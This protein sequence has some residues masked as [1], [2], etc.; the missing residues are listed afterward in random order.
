MKRILLTLFLLCASSTLSYAATINVHAGDNLQ[1][2]INNAQPGDTLILDAG[3][4]FTGPITLPA[5][6]G[7]SYITI[8]SSALAQLPAAGVRVS[9]SNSAQMPR[10]V[11]PGLGYAALMTASGASYYSFIGVEFATVNPNDTVDTLITLGDGNTSAQSILAQIPHHLTF[12][13]CY[14]HAS[15]T[16]DLKRGIGLNSRETSVLNSYL[17][18]FKSVGNDSQ[19]IGGWNGPG[20]FHIINNYLEGAGENILFGGA[21]ANNSNNQPSDIEIRR[22]LITKPLSWRV[23]DPSYAGTHWQVKNL[24]EL[25]NAQRVTIEGNILEN[26]W[27]D[28]QGGTA[29][30]F[31][32]RNQ[33]GTNLW[34]GINNVTFRNNVIRHANNGIGTL[35]HDDEHTSQFLHDITVT[36]NLLYDLD[37][38]VW[39]SPGNGGGIFISFN[40][41]G[42]YNLTIQH[43]TAYANGIGYFFEANT[44]LSG[45]VIKDNISHAHYLWNGSAGTNALNGAAPNGGWTA[46]RDV[47]VLE[48]YDGSVSYWQ[49]Y[50]T[51]P[52]NTYLTATWA[53]VGFSNASNSN[54]NDFRLTASSPYKGLATDGKDI[55]CDI[56]ALNAA[57]SAQTQAGFSDDFSSNTRDTTKWNLGVTTIDATGIDPSVSVS[58]QNGQLAITPKPYTAGLHYNGYTTTQA[59]DFTGGTISVQLIQPAGDYRAPAV[60]SVGIDANNYCRIDVTH[61]GTTDNRVHMYYRINGGAETVTEV[62]NLSSAPAY[63]RLR[64]LTTDDTIVWETSN[65]G[66]NWTLRRQAAGG[67]SLSSVHVDL[68]SGTAQYIDVSTAAIFDNFQLQGQSSEKRFV[69]DT[70]TGADGTELSTHLGETGAAWVNGT[71]EPYAGSMYISNANRLRCY[72]RSYYYAGGSPASAEYDIQAD[73]VLVGGTPGYAGLLGRFDPVP[74]Y[75]YRVMWD[76]GSQTLILQKSTATTGGA[77]MLGTYTPGAPVVGSTHTIKLEIRNST[78]K[79]Y[80]DGVPVI[81]STDNELTGAGKVGIYFSTTSSNTSGWHVDNF[82]ASNP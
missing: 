69:F 41:T 75:F 9:P 54:N 12:D 63:L 76:G 25:K 27:A 17:S 21:D 43:N 31:T 66:T 19:A 24:L 52:P 5:K 13:R 67:F 49:T 73:F 62:A 45:L 65:D 42:A 60:L 64:H 53:N 16:Q 32:P 78:K 28:A 47:L 70:F 7:G 56:D 77:V 8:Q 37:P 22:N 72:D 46:Q 48:G 58:Q 2:A 71:N 61:N 20:P 55:G 1:T 40:N 18:G 39:S 44:Q 38:S 3:V 35:S 4:S 80:Y 36:N 81:S 74:R 15:F 51:A 23:G 33:G 29:I 57:M 50:Y 68:Y 14:I 11:S 26:C 79:V 30:L 34:A 6:N 10:I 59:Y 82:S